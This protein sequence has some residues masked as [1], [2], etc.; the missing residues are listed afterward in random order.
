MGPGWE[1]SWQG[2][3]STDGTTYDPVTLY[4]ASG[5]E[6]Q[7]TDLTGTSPNYYYNERMVAVTNG[8]G[9]LVAYDLLYPSGAKDVYGFLATDSYGNVNKAYLSQKIDEHGRTTT[10]VY[11]PFSVTNLVVQLNYVIDPDGKTNTLSYT[12]NSTYNEL[13]SKVQDPSGHTASFAYDANGNLTNVTDVIGLSSS[14]GYGNFAVGT[15]STGYT[16]NLWLNQLTTPYGTTGFTFTDDNMIEYNA[17]NRSIVITEPNGSHQIFA[18]YGWLVYLP[19]SYSSGTDPAN[20]PSVQPAGSTLDGAAVMSFRNT[21]YWGRQQFENLS[22]TFRATGATNWDFTKLSA[23]DYGVGRMQHWN[24]ADDGSQSDSL[25]MEQDPSPDGSTAGKM[26]WYDY[27]G[28]PFSVVQGS[29]SSP[30]LVIK[31][32]PDG[33]EWYQQY[34]VDQFGNRTNIISTYSSGGSVL[35]RTNRYVYA[36]NGVDLLQS[37]RPDGITDA[38][39]AYDADHQVL[40]MT[41]ALGEVTAY[42][43]NSNEQVTSMTQP[44]GLLATNIYGAD[45]FLAQKIV[46]GFSTNSYTYTNGLVYTHTDERGLTTTNTWDA[47]QRLVKVAYPDGTA[48]AYAYNKLDLASVVDRMGFTN[49]YAYNAV[50][51]K[52]AATNALGNVTVYDYCECGALSEII[53]ALGNITQFSHD[54]QGNLIQTIYPDGYT[55]NNVYNSIKQLAVR[56]DSSGMAVTNYYNNQGLLTVSSNNVGQVKAQVYDIDDRITNSVDANAVSMGMNYDNLNRLLTRSYPDGGVE[57]YGYTANISGPTSYTN[58]IG[59]VV[60]Y[61]YDTMNR[62]TN[63][64]YVGVTTNKF[65][66]NGAGDLLTLTDGKNDNTSWQYDQFGRV[67]NKMDNLGT[68]LFVYQ[69]DPDNRLTNRWSAAKGSTA[70]SYDAVG[71]L[72]QVTYPVSPSITLQYDA[73]NRLTNMVDAVGTTVYGYD[74]VGQLL[75]ENGPWSNDTLSYTYANRLRTGLSL[76]G[77]P[78]NQSY[79]Y[80]AARRLTSVTS[81]AGEFDY[82][83]DPVKLQRVHTLTL[84]NGAVITNA[85]DSV[86]RLTLTELM[87]STGADL[88]SYA[89][90]YNQ[91]N[92]R[93]NVVRAAGNYVN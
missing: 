4:G 77:T 80:D 39:Y 72:T 6:I 66:Y 83:Y 64:V 76:I 21:F 65:I 70:Y 58:Q 74:A 28:K 55:V 46:V 32:L 49:S 73:L 16:T 26:T 84:P 61:G 37:I 22:A 89:Y 93:T 52:I 54:N 92:Q 25:S 27:P 60:L 71:N 48:I 79:G 8:L 36:A 38:A 23:T 50:R 7:F 53:D 45:G 62:K 13:I 43:Y 10:F 51:Q 17:A 75:S 86:A 9:N 78:W 33:S 1:F 5:G 68:N 19:S 69:Y 87:S 24:D 47:L 59:N 2:Y 35:T 44:N 85:Y 31:V 91:A 67:T 34:Q 30:S 63:E 12:N 88:D 40:F 14:F 82:A 57:K 20:Y 81:P 11:S 90:G 29:S 41:N 56:T 15:A 18:Y 3:I 42:T